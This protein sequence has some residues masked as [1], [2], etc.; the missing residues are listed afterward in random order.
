MVFSAGRGNGITIS[1][2]DADTTPIETTLT[3]TCGT[4]TLGTTAGLTFTAGDGTG[5]TTMTFTGTI[6]SINAAL[7]GMTFTLEPG[8]TGSAT[9]VVSVNDLGATGTSGAQV[10]TATINISAAAVAAIPTV[11][12]FGLLARGR[13][14][15]A[16]AGLRPK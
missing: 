11:S 10:T 16:A 7:D 13:A 12:F 1:D 8:C 14:R 3:A 6:T 15:S 2:P 9:L 5:D 4:I